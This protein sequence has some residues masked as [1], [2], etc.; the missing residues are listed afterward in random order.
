MRC[1]N[2][3]KKNSTRIYSTR[4]PVEEPSTA[5][6]SESCAAAQIS[7]EDKSLLPSVKAPG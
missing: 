6:I 5:S 4:V 7:G 3:E 2:F 1:T